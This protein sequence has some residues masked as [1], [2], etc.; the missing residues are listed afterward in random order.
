MTGSAAAAGVTATSGPVAPT[1]TAEAPTRALQL[2][3]APQTTRRPSSS[4]HEPTAH[5]PPPPPAQAPGPAQSAV[6]L[7]PARRVARGRHCSWHFP[8]V[9]S[10]MGQIILKP[11]PACHRPSASAVWAAIASNECFTHPHSPCAGACRAIRP[12]V[13][14]PLQRADRPRITSYGAGLSRYSCDFST[15]VSICFNF[16]LII[17][18]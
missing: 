1:P 10:A 15:V 7:W 14:A 2:R 13:G 11:P 12:A 16:F 4:P 3:P 8:S 5:R 6:P 9:V 17:E 18:R